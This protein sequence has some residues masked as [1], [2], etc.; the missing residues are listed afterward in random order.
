MQIPISNHGTGI[1]LAFTFSYNS[2]GLNKLGKNS[3]LYLLVLQ[4]NHYSMSIKFYAMS[5]VRFTTILFLLLVMS[6]ASFAHTTSDTCK[7]PSSPG[8]KFIPSGIVLSTAAKNTLNGMAKKLKDNPTCRLNVI[9]HGYATYK[10][11]QLGWDRV[12]TVIEYL[13]T[14]GIPEDQ[15]IFTIGY[16][17]NPN[18]VDLVA[19]M[20]DGPTKIPPPYPPASKIKRVKSMSR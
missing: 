5:F 13:Y 6:L 20:E 4:A 14:K 7:I 1:L 9:G 11:Q 8:V 15:F 3:D 17:G 2:P 18:L 10:A 16:D 19:T 12:M